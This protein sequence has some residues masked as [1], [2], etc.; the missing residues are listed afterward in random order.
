MASGATVCFDSSPTCCLVGCSC[1]LCELLV[2]KVIDCRWFAQGSP[3][4]VKSHGLQLQPQE[5]AQ[6]A[7][8]GHTSR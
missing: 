7:E 1:L 4:G 8:H 5:L 3:D 6:N 2:L